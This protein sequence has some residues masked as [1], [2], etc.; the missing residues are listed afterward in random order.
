MNSLFVAK[1][2]TE[3]RQLWSGWSSRRCVPWNNRSMAVA[4][5]LAVLAPA[6][7]GQFALY[8]VDGDTERLPG[9]VFNLG[10]SYPGES[11]SARFRVR[12]TSDAPALLSQ[13]AVRGTGFSI[14]GFS[15][16]AGIPARQALDFTVVFRADTVASYSAELDVESTSVLLT[17]SVLPRLTYQIAGKSL[18]AGGID[19]GSVEAGSTVSRRVTVTNLTASP[20]PLPIPSVTGDAFFLPSPP[21]P[22]LMSPAQSTEFEIVFRPTGAGAWSG[23]LQIDDR[24]YSLTGMSL[25][26]PVPRPTLAINLPDPQSARDGS[27]AISFDAPSRSAGSG[28]ITLDFTPLAKG[29]SDPAIQLGIVGRW[30]PFTIAPGDTALPA[31]N[32]QT[33]TTAG[34]IG[35]TVELGGVTDRKTVV[36]PAAPVAILSAQATRIAGAIDVRITAF[37]NTRTAGAVTFTFFDSTGATY[38]IPLDYTADFASY[39]AISDA[40]GAFLLHSVFPVSGDAAKITE[41]A[42]QM[43][44]AA[45]SATTGRVKF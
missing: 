38:A 1:S 7:W 25:A 42:V 4:A 9:A 45:G 34:T 32:F 3:P 27:I 22:M 26:L 5:L 12:N 35:F 18:G 6:A 39:F 33:G 16:P 17:A 37:D 14:V 10:T 43:T 11:V 23:S 15:T 41:F 2:E 40:G 31:V 13:L 29:A 19:F 8:Q 30:L 28:S 36:I 24:A 44:N 21:V 20:L